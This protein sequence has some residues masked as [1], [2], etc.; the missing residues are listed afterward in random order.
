MAEI[1]PGYMTREE[2]D[3]KAE[4]VQRFALDLLDDGEAQILADPTLTPEM[5]AKVR[6]HFEAARAQ[7]R[8]QRAPWQSRS[9]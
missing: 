2:A 4:E 1:P 3:R 8:A 9:H 6:R 5:V 7:I